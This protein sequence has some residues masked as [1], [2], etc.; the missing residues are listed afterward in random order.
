MN[1]QLFDFFCSVR[2]SLL[3][4]T[5]HSL[6]TSVHLIC[7]LVPRLPLCFYSLVCIQWIT[8]A[9]K[10]WKTGK[11]WEH[12]SH[13]V[14]VRWTWDG[15]CLT[16]NTCAINLRVSFLNQQEHLKSC[17]A[18]EH[19][20]MKSSTLFDCEP[21]PSSSLVPRFYLTA[22]EKTCLRTRLPL[23]YVQ[24]VSTWRHSCDKCFQAF[25]VFRRSSAYMCYCERK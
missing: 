7:S 22:V 13:D 11:A 2:F 20:T 19:S 21:L 24:I 10:R 9:E 4:S 23:P 12:L 25:P 15:R 8:E 5:M 6:Y 1:L 17:L 3:P 14:D 16:I 18:V